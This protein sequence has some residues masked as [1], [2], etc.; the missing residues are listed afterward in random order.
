MRLVVSQ[1]DERFEAWYWFTANS[2]VTPNYYQQQWW[3]MLDAI[4]R[5]P[6]TGTLVRISTPLNDSAASHRRLLAFVTSLDASTPAPGQSSQAV[7]EPETHLSTV[8]RAGR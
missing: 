2:R 8:S 6:M 1:G 5:K 7:G 4:R 3:L